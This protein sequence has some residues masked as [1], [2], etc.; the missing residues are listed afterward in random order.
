MFNV[1]DVYYG[2]TLLCFV[3]WTFRWSMD[4][5]DALVKL[6][7]AVM[8]FA[9]FFLLLVNFGFVIQPH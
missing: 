7:F 1:L 5:V 4:G 3:Y 9:T 2:L 8:S 6:F